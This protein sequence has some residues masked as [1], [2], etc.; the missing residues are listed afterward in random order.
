MLANIA[1]ASAQS[2]ALSTDVHPATTFRYE[3]LDFIS[4]ELPRWRDDPER[5]IHTS[6]PALTEYLCDHLS[7]A[8]RKSPGW[9][10]LQFRTEITD[11]QQRGRRIDLAPK[12]CGV[13]I[14]ING[15]GYTKYESLL[16]IECKRLPTPL[17]TDRDER[18]YVF[19][20]HATTGGIQRFKAGHHGAAHT[21]G[22]MIAFVQDETMLVWDKRVAE[23]I[24]ELVDSGQP[25]WTAKDLLRP[26]HDDDTLQL[27]VFRSSH[28][29]ERGLPEIELC[30]LW[31]KM[32]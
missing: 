10:I 11:E 6:E 9:D 27:A 20:R 7:S 22:A 21:V 26:E 4:D 17:G 3:L 5:P 15:K 28:T 24:Q 31:L 19:N 32:N 13:T 1:D 12:P 18:E 25:G 2:G 16:P 8:A 23:W 14:W 30:H 29:R